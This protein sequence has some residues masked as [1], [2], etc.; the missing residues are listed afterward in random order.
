MWIQFNNRKLEETWDAV[1]NGKNV[2]LS[3]EVRVSIKCAKLTKKEIG[4]WDQK[5]PH[6][7]V[8]GKASIYKD[9][10]TEVLIEK[11]DEFH[12]RFILKDGSTEQ[13]SEKFSLCKP[14][15]FWYAN[16]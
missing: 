4:T 15:V 13:T 5:I 14:S 16:Y 1:Q 10:Q 9:G 12:L 8:E 2:T 11:L 3:D 7:F 6:K